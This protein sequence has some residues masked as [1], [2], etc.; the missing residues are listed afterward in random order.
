M[1]PRPF[2]LTSTV[3]VSPPPVTAAVTLGEVGPSPLTK[4]TI[5]SPAEG[6]LKGG[7]D[8]VPRPLT[9]TCRSTTIGAD[10]AGVTAF[11][12]AD[13]ALLPALFDA[14]TRKV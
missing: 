5:R 3:H 1:P 11:E 10:A 6:V 2:D 8:T 4:A 7:V 12:G 9:D 14:T 13:I